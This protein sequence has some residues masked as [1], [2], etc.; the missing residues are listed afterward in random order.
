[1][2]D[3]TQPY[4]IPVLLGETIDALRVKPDGLYLDGTLG[5]GGHAE[6]ILG[7]GGRLIGVDRDQDAI[8]HVQDRFSRI[9]EFAGRYELV[10]DNF[11]N[12]HSSLLTPNSS[13]T[14]DGAIL[15]LGVSSHQIDLAGRGFSYM[16]DA[17]LDMRM[18]QGQA[19]S[20]Y[21]IVN[22]YP[23]SELS[24]ILY[25]FGEERSA[26][27]IAKA[28]A[29]ARA[30]KPIETT[31]ELSKIVLSC[32][33]PFIKGGH[34]AK[35]TFQS[36]RIEVNDELSGLMQA[37]KDIVDLLAPGA[38][39]AVISFHS[40][41]TSAVRRA[42]RELASDCI[43]DKSQPICV[44]NH[45][46]S[47]KLIEIKGITPTRQEQELNSRSASASLRVIEKLPPRN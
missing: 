25:T 11:K 19:L 47:V 32:F 34:P 43:C 9:P 2:A 40:L 17:P 13:L 37:L 38:R 26:R 46:A 41:E 8:A 44:C 45:K 12:I 6:E 42:F 28:I 35:R 4:H 15:D 5:G 1:M 22:E 39:L 10:H 29:A 3:D 21:N 18:N 30:K 27:R 20:A 7:R 33:P 23:E 31:L 14:F 24:R 36:L 16:A